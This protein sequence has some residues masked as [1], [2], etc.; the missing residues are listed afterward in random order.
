MNKEIANFLNPDI[1]PDYKAYLE[2][3][4]VVKDVL[5]DGES[6]VKDG[7]VSI[8]NAGGDIEAERL[9]AMAAEAKLNNKIDN[10][11]NRAVLSEISLG[12]KVAN[13]ATKEDIDNL[14]LELRK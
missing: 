8:E 10:E 9:R 11:T 12:E 5:V 1:L 14:F 7:I 2:K 13:I 3:K 4:P 6:I